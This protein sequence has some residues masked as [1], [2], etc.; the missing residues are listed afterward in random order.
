MRFLTIVVSIIVGMALCAIFLGNG[1]PVHVK[2]EPFI[3]APPEFHGFWY[4]A[5]WKVMVFCVAVGAL[6]GYLLGAS[7]HSGHKPP[8]HRPEAPKKQ[9]ETDYLLV[10]RRESR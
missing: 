1:H 4:I 10:D 9:H 5:L 8:V 3:T 6:L 2:L 7:A